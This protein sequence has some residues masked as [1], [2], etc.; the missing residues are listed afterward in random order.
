MSIYTVH[1]KETSDQPSAF[2]RAVFVRDGF[3]WWALV[4]GPLWLLW[5]RAWL[6]FVI[7][8][9][10]QIALGLLVQSHVIHMGTQSLLELLIAVALGFEAASIRRY[11]LRRRGFHLVD[12]VQHRR[13]VDA[14][15]RFFARF[16]MANTTPVT[17]PAASAGTSPLVGLF[18]S[19]GA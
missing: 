6:G 4:L 13:L 3:G 18:P 10:F 16:E 14:E 12:V 5:N 15:R 7:W 19:A 2:E 1:M 9:L 17:R 8:C 11:V